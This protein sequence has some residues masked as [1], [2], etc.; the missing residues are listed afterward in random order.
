MRSALQAG[1]HCPQ[2]L[3]PVKHKSAIAHMGPYVRL[4]L[5]LFRAIPMSSTSFS[6]LR[7]PRGK[8]PLTGCLLSGCRDT[9]EFSSDC[10]RRLGSDAGEPL[11]LTSDGPE[12]VD[13]L[14]VL[15]AEYV[16]GEAR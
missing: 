10:L 14:D 12:L 2:S 9:V 16:P 8:L 5:W 13:R 15:S 11:K 6:E 1:V 3:T 4:S 7:G